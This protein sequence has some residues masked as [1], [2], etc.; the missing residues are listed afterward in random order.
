MDGQQPAG[1][2]SDAQ[3][4]RFLDNID[5]NLTPGARL[6]APCPHGNADAAAGPARARLLV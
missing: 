1:L 5:E 6:A 4:T 2:M 3:L